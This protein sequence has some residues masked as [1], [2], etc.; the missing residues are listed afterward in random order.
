MSINF[1][2]DCGEQTVEREMWSWKDKHVTETVDVCPECGRVYRRG[3]QHE[4]LPLIQPYWGDDDR[5]DLE[6]V[7]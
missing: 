5:P 6:I 3:I 7:P 2:L 1:C 4:S